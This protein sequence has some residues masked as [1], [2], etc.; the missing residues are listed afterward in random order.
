MTGILHSSSSP[1]SRTFNVSLDQ[2]IS[3]WVFPI[4]RTHPVAHGTASQS[5]AIAG[6]Q[7]SLVYSPLPI[8]TR[9]V[10]A[11]FGGSKYCSSYIALVCT[12]GTL[13]S[14]ILTM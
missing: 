12:R 10:F 8:S 11:H 13:H 9:T 2:Q 6:G 7:V 14:I 5:W 3:E 4:C 1:F